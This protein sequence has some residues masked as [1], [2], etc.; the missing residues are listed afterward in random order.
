MSESEPEQ[1][2]PISDEPRLRKRVLI[3]GTVALVAAAVLVAALLSITGQPPTFTPSDDL[4]T[5]RLLY[6]EQG[7]Q[8][9]RRYALTLQTGQRALVAASWSADDP[10]PSPDGKWLANWQ[11]GSNYYEW[12]LM[13]RNTQTHEL[14]NLGTFISASAP[15]TWS[16]DSQWILFSAF[17]PDAAPDTNVNIDIDTDFENAEA[18]GMELWMINVVSGETKRLTT[19]D[20]MDTNPAMSPDG[21]HIAYTSSAN[22]YHAL[23]VMDMDT[24]AMHLLTPDYN[25]Y[26][27]AWSPDGRWIAFVNLMVADIDYNDDIWVIRADG[28]DAQPITTG[29]AIETN[30]GWES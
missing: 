4:P 16:P 9:S 11:E 17:P 15:P 19:N 12:H 27:A 13:V 30:P 22:G 2:T 3:V 21:K 10:L 1:P 26:S 5:A 20:Y 25:A 23:Y 29:P 7:K 24:G 28:T 18:E 6:T 14:R 8:G